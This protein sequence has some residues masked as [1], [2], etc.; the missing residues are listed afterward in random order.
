MRKYRNS[1]SSISLEKFNIYVYIILRVTR[2]H[3][4][5]TMSRYFWDNSYYVNREEN[6]SY[7]CI[8]I[9]IYKHYN[10]YFKNF[11]NICYCIYYV[12]QLQIV[13]LIK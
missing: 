7:T 12:Y 13:I 3:D 6:H 4:T 5:H 1:G 10:Y 9:Y 2:M 11:E 8:Y